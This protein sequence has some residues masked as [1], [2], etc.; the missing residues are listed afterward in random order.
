MWGLALLTDTSLRIAA[1][2]L[3]PTHMAANV[4]QIL[5]IAVYTL[6]FG[7]TIYSSRRAHA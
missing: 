7:W 4:S 1:I 6:L 3:L 2:Y 5:M